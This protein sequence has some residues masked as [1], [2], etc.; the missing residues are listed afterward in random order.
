MDNNTLIALGV[1]ILVPI[2][3]QLLKVTGIQGSV[4]RW[5]VFILSLVA[6]ACI[7]VVG[8]VKL[9]DLTD[10]VAFLQALGPIALA[11]F[12]ASQLIYAE[13]LKRFGWLGADKPPVEPV[14]PADQ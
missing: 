12:G 4:A 6:G 2:I 13:L 9:P 7:A 14:V 3:G 10:P 1:T 5:V 8:G 11:V